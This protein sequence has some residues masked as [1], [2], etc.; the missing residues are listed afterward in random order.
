MYTIKQKIQSE[1]ATTAL[2]ASATSAFPRPSFFAKAIPKVV[3]GSFGKLEKR[4]I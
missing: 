4:Y 1:D 3:T 2:L